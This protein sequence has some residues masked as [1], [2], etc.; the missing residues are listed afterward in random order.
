M[1]TA[2]LS[3]ISVLETALAG[4]VARIAVLEKM[5]GDPP[6]DEPVETGSGGDRQLTKRKLAQRWG[7]SPRTIDRRRMK[8]AI[9]PPDGIVDGQ[10]FWWLSTVMRHEATQVGGEAPNRSGYLRAWEAKK[11]AAA[12]D[13]AS[14][15]ASAAS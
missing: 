9:P 7:R 8:R 3:R 14:K 15:E 11:E 13:V 6:A 2:K 4:L 5:L 10:L 12:K 1:G